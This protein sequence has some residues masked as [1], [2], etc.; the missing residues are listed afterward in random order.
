MPSTF[1]L[2]EMFTPASVAVVGASASPTGWGGTTFLKNLQQRGFQG[3]LFP[4]NPKAGEVAGLKCYPDVRALPEAPDLVIV[5]VPA[6]R[7]PGVLR[8]C[9]ARGVKNVHIFTSGFSETGEKEGRHLDVEITAIIRESDLRVVG[10][11]CMGLWVPSCRLTYWGDEPRGSGGLTLLSQSGGHGEYLTYYAQQIGLY[12]NK[13]IS[14]GN[15]RGLQV[16]D[17]L[18]YLAGDA[19]TQ[20]IACYFEG[21]KNGGR[22][23]ELIKKIGRTKPVFVWKSGLT[24]SGSRAVSSHTGSLAGEESI[25]RAFFAQTGAVK[26]D[27][28]EEIVDTALAFQYLRPSTGRRV[29]LVG[30]GGGNSVALADICSHEGL[31]VPHLTDGT[32]RELNKFIRLAGHSVRNP[33]DAWPAQDDPEIFRQTI[34]L[35][36]NDPNIDCV[37]F[38]RHVWAEDMSPQYRARFDQVNDDLIA[39]I[40]KGALHKPVVV[41]LMGTNS[42][43]A[44]VN[45]KLEL[46]KKFIGAGIPAYN[47]T[48]SAARSLRRFVGYHEFLSREG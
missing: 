20:M 26:V 21:M 10:P 37:I 19:G 2:D 16:S 33:L 48:L 47:S 23:V 13:I 25:W 12:F 45:M 44:S 28:L 8:D 15:A 30:G 5:A 24:A 11:N 39:L 38:D 42:S 3:K 9:I 17:F 46:W 18:E 14:F 6:A 1:V 4:V 40:K 36:A 27:S 34:T 43:Q 31:E 32:R 35:A 29:L 41:S 22:V 7:V